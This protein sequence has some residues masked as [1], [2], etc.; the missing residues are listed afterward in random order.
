MARDE[1]A[2]DDDNGVIVLGG[3]FKPHSSRL[4]ITKSSEECSILRCG[5]AL[6]LPFASED[7]HSATTKEHGFAGLT[8]QATSYSR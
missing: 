8:D 5:V 4:K 6:P 7:A 3:G 2:V 1:K